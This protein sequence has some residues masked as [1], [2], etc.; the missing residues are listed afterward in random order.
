MSLHRE[1]PDPSTG[2]EAPEMS[3][4]AR[5]FGADR[6]VQRRH[7]AACRGP[8]QVRAPGQSAATGECERKTSKNPPFIVSILGPARRRGEKLASL[9][10]SA[11]PLTVSVPAAR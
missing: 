3:C 7:V 1:L 10:K 8:A 6:P 5:H 4:K 9:I 11:L 2:R